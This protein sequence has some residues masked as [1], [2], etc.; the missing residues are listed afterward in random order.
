MRRT[1]SRRVRRRSYNLTALSGSA[2]G[3]LGIMPGN[4]STYTTPV[5]RYAK[6]QI[7]AN[8]S[9]VKLDAGRQVKVYGGGGPCHFILEVTGYYL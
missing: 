3:S 4:A 1:R 6:G 8:A 5:V 9:I 7:I 2:S